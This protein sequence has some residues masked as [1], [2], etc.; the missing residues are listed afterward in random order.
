MHPDDLDICKRFV[1]I[2]P[3]RSKK[4][5]DVFVGSLMFSVVETRGIEPLTSKMRIFYSHAINGFINGFFQ[6]HRCR[7][8]MFFRGIGCQIG[9]QKI[10]SYSIRTE[11]HTVLQLSTINP[12]KTCRLRN[13]CI[14]IDPHLL[15]SIRYSSIG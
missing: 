2:L 9:C 6:N 11:R 12:R 8:Y 1:A 3:R 7:F 4:A 10:P 15:E 13:M 5:S 14:V